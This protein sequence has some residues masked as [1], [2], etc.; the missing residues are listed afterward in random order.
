MLPA[1]TCCFE[2][3][4]S[5]LFIFRAFVGFLHDI[6]PGAQRYG[7]AGKPCFFGGRKTVH[8]V[9][10]FVEHIDDVSTRSSVSETSIVVVIAQLP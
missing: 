9:T 3:R 1:N 6:G 2:A 5:P 4:Y 8:M 10:D 7:Y